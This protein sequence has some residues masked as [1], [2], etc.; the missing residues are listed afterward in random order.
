[1]RLNVQK[2]KKLDQGTIKVLVLFIQT[3]QPPSIDIFS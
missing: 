2:K 1:M 3:L